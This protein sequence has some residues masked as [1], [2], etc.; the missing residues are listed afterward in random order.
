SSTS[1]LL[2]TLLLGNNI[3]NILGASVASAVCVDLM[4]PEWGVFVAAV[5]MTLVV[6]LLGEIFPK[7]VAAHHPRG[8][9]NYVAIP[10]YLIHN[11]LRPLHILM[12]RF[13]SPLVEKVAGG[14]AVLG[15]VSRTDEILR[16]ARQESEEAETAPTGSVRAIIGA[17]AGASEMTVS[18]IMV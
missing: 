1:R 11:A 18:D 13:L 10:L 3:A 8:V 4:G 7:A 17:A 2:F 14:P 6:F 15:H 16:L 5:S 9:S 12:D